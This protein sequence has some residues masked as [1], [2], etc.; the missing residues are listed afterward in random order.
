M[1]NEQRLGGNCILVAAKSLHHDF[2]K[3]EPSL[4][5]SD[6]FG[7]SAGR[8]LWA[9]SLDSSPGCDRSMFLIVILAP[10]VL[11][12]V[13][14]VLHGFAELIEQHLLVHCLL[15]IARIEVYVSDPL[16]TDFL[17]CRFHLLFFVFF[18]F[19]ARFQLLRPPFRSGH[20]KTKAGVHGH[21]ISNNIRFEP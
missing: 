12:D 20:L 9:F 14:H 18:L 21:T 4:F 16:L 2:G 19:T 3:G 1:T 10:S 15:L 17:R 7:K 13:E 11:E 8:F 6:G 5:G